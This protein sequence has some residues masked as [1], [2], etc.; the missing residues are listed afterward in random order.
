[1]P[2]KAES[3]ILTELTAPLAVLADVAS[4]FSKTYHDLAIKSSSQFLP[5]PITSLSN[6]K[7]NGKFLAL[8]LG[9]SNLRVAVVELFGNSTPPPSEAPVVSL[10]LAGEDAGASSGSEYGSPSSSSQ[11][12]PLG[13]TTPAAANNTATIPNDHF[14]PYRFFISPQRTWSIP[15]ELKCTQ[16]ECLFDW[17]G[18]CIATV[19]RTY[20]CQ[21]TEAEADE[22]LK[23]GLPLGVTFSFPMVQESHTSAVLMP[24]G[25]GF[26]FETTNDL[27]TL[28]G[29][30]YAKQ[31]ALSESS[32]QK[33]P[34]VE[35]V[36]ITNDSISTLLAGS[37]VY[38]G[39]A[40]VG[41]IAGTGTNATCL[42]PVEKLAE[43]KKPHGQQQGNVAGARTTT[44]ILLNTEWSI[45]GTL[46]PLERFVTKWDR[47]LDRE[48][49]KPGFQPFEEMV[50]GRYLGELV[51]L[52]SLD[53]L[54]ENGSK[55]LPGKFF[56]PYAVKTE[57]CGGVEGEMNIKR[58]AV[59]LEEYFGKAERCK[60]VWDVDS[61]SMF[62][63]ICETVSTRAAALVAAATMGI[64]TVND[65]LRLEADTEVDGEVDDVVISYT[66]TILE[67]YPGFRDRCQRFLTEIAER[68]YA[69]VEERVGRKVRRRN[70]RLVEARDGGL[71]GAAVLAGMVRGGTT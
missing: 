22:I 39:S 15:A 57:L 49:E 24:M 53:V 14:S 54:G 52:V 7:E 55:T 61:A 35:V 9:G 12:L 32:A 2:T 40:T 16:A 41:I 28:L 56:T 69:V 68:W 42:C 25:K 62:K 34:K 51:R 3:T 64:L 60:W 6:G 29:N 36:A 37:Y 70:V 58:V 4:A 18:E 71:V 1:M 67:R 43:F 23:T 33:L 44:H 17:V 10:E 47:I 8:D 65:D 38:Y 13:K 46:P 30:A 26:T 63:K 5:T 48:N 45:N 21:T 31:R 59:L 11:S 66:G 20:L 27:A 50:G 19:I